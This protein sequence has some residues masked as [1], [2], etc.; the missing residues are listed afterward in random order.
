MNGRNWGELVVWQA[1]HEFVL[2]LHP[3]LNTLPIE[4]RFALA[5][6]MRRAAY[7]VPANIVEGH[8]KGS[9]KEF[10]KYLYIARGS[11]EEL[12]YFLL[13]S[14]DL[15][16]LSSET[17]E[18]FNAKASKISAMINKLITSNKERME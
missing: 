15:N 5:D 10:N 1:S 11:L 9:L 4:E 2:M 7:S 17:Y 14:R 16:Y 8:A 18:Q 6:Q 3:F 12:K 13:L